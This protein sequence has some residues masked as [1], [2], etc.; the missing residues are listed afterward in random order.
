M[1]PESEPKEPQITVGSVPTMEWMLERLVA[2]GEL[3]YF[4]R[5][6]VKRDEL[7]KQ[8][9]IAPHVDGERRATLI[10]MLREYRERSG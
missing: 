1:E 3:R 4:R 10:R 6:A 8:Y 5:N 9:D 7:E 2:S